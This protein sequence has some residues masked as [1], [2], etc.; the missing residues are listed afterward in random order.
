[1]IQM[2]ALLLH[3]GRVRERKPSL[4]VLYYI[5]Q[6]SRPAHIKSMSSTAGF[7]TQPAL[8]VGQL[9]CPEH[10]DAL[11]VHSAIHPHL[12]VRGIAP[13]AFLM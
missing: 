13:A 3:A 7:L 4:A 6:L 8:G 9:R 1:M 11:P 2:L 5:C 10:V 12:F